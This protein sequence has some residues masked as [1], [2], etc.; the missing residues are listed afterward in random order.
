MGPSPQQ[1][2]GEFTA[3]GVKTSCTAS[4]GTVLWV[5]AKPPGKTGSGAAVYDRVPTGTPPDNSVTVVASS[6]TPLASTA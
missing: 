2:G 4:K 6:I 3:V 5:P 1:G